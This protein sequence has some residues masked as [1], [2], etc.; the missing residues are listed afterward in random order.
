MKLL[1]LFCGAGGAAVGYA[2]AGFEVMGVDIAAQKNYPFAFHQGDAI[3]FLLKHG[4]EYDAVHASPPCQHYSRTKTLAANVDGFQRH[5]DRIE[6]PDLIEAT[7]DG[8]RFV[9]VPY[10][11]ENVVGA[12][13]LN[14]VMLCGTMFDLRVFRHRLLFESNVSLIA[15]EHRRHVG[16]TNSHRGYSRDADYICV[17]GNNYD[18]K[19]GREAMGIEWMTSRAELSQ[20]IPPAYSHFLGTQLMAHLCALEVAPC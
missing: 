10:I 6:H 7:P 13:L 1:D 15:P 17:C 8:L 20:A 19:Q 2:R 11:I 9:G 18:A 4:H 5:C 16:T 14:P 12:P 3:E